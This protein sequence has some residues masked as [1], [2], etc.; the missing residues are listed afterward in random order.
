MKGVYKQ[1]YEYKQERLF[2]QREKK[3]GIITDALKEIP[4]NAVLRDKLQGF[5]KKY[6]ELKAENEV[7]LSKVKDFENKEKYKIHNG[8]AFK[9]NQDGK[10]EPTPYCPNCYLVISDIGRGNYECLSPKCKYRTSPRSV[11]SILVKELN[12]ILQKAELKD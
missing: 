1:V 6:E 10:A 5:E 12:C 2:H 8:I 4:I 11:A 3:M 9:V 7:L